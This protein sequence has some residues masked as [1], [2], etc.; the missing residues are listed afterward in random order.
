MGDSRRDPLSG[1]CGSW[2]QHREGE[3]LQYVFC[4]VACAV[5]ARGEARDVTSAEEDAV[6][7]VRWR[8]FVVCDECGDV[9]GREGV[10][11]CVEV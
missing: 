3:E 11:E 1:C 10:E 8:A 9:G 7:S 2:A 4:G 6:G 5:A